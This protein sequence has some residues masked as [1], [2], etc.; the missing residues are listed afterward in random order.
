NHARDRLR[1]GGA[2]FGRGPGGPCGGKDE[3]YGA[4]KHVRL[5]KARDFRPGARLSSRGASRHGD[6][7]PYRPDRSCGTARELRGPSVL[8]AFER[9]GRSVRKVL[10]LLVLALAARIASG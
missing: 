2:V 5:D 9:L 4:T 6:A 10:A 8:G 3:G 1:N 7:L